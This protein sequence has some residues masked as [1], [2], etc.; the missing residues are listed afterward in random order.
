MLHF[1]L[2]ASLTFLS[3]PSVTVVTP[4]REQLVLPAAAHVARPIHHSLTFTL[5]L[6]RHKGNAGLLLGQLPHS[7]PPRLLCHF[8]L[9]VIASGVQFSHD[10]IHQWMDLWGSFV[11]YA[12]AL[13]EGSSYTCPLSCISEGRETRTDSHSLAADITVGV[14]FTIRLQGKLKIIRKY[15][16]LG[17]TL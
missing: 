10:R 11:S 15:F 16:R 3:L 4:E 2:S 1:S 14:Y 6:L 13:L 12:A 8:P 17:N 9:S 7:L 5:D